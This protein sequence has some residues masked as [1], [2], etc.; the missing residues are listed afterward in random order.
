VL[1][2]GHEVSIRVATVAVAACT[3]RS[4]AEGERRS[5]RRSPASRKPLD[6]PYPTPIV[7]ALDNA[8]TASAACFQLNKVGA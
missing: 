1:T 2:S 5:G 4:C 8:S 7:A 3:W 6:R